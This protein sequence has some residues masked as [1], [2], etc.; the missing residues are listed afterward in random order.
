MSSLQSRATHYVQEP[1]NEP[2]NKIPTSG[3]EGDSMREM[4]DGGSMREVK[5]K[6]KRNFIVKKHKVGDKIHLGMLVD[7]GADAHMVPQGMFDIP[8]NEEKAHGFRG[9]RRDRDA[10]TRNTV[11]TWIYGT[12]L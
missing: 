12:E 10:L 5:Q 1:L 3:S 11:H 2:A 8:I 6:K 7:S 9:R 4:K